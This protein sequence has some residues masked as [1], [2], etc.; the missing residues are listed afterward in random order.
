MTG[1]GM[2]DSEAT[3]VTDVCDATDGMERVVKT[4]VLVKSQIALMSVSNHEVR[5]SHG[6][7]YVSEGVPNREK[8]GRASHLC[9]VVGRAT[10][11]HHEFS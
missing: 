8:H 2:G 9:T 7:E 11:L 6:M 4:I 1:A 3:W 5:R 10:G